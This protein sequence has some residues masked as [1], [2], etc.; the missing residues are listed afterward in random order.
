VRIALST[1]L[2][3]IAE[4]GKEVQAVAKQG[5]SVR[6]AGISW[7][8]SRRRDE[9]HLGQVEEGASQAGPRLIARLAKDRCDIV[10]LLG[11]GCYRAVLNA[12]AE[13]LKEE[14][15]ERKQDF[16]KPFAEARFDTLHCPLP[17]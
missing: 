16:A 2:P 11:R 4:A 3:F 7:R 9:V 13:D 15:R 8:G 6:E 5:Q 17:P 10:Q 12:T 1:D 14:E